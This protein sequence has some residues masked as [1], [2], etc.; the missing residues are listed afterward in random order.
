MNRITADNFFSIIPEWVLY[1]PISANAVRLYATLQRYADKD[2]GACHPSRRTLAAKCHTTTKTVD[3]ALKELVDIGAVVMHQRRN[4]NGDL[5]S[6]HYTVITASGVGTKTTLPSDKNNPTGRDKNDP[7]TIVSMNHSQERS[8]AQTLADQWWSDYKS[9]T[10]G[11]TPT[12][13]GAWHSLLAVIDGALKAGW[14]DDMVALGLSRCV[15]VPSA[16]MLDRVLVGLP[17]PVRSVEP[18]VALKH[19]RECE[20]CGGIGFITFIDENGNRSAY[21]CDA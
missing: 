14:S 11:R 20:A 15:S 10:G 2:T 4:A 8:A 5:T 9:R 13:K 7:Q 12:G 3:R 17:A 6:N 21:K 18:V 19:D 1:A 16:A